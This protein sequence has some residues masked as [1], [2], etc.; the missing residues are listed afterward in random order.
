MNRMLLALAL[1]IVWFQARAE[2]D[3][4]PQ[5]L[6][7]PSTY[8]PGTAFSFQVLVP[9]LPDFT[10]YTI[11]ILFDTEVLDPDLTLSAVP[12]A[13]Q[14]PFPTT[15]GFTSSG[16][17]IAGTASASITFSDSSL[18]GVFTTPGVNDLLAVVTVL[19]GSG[20]TGTITISFGS[21]TELLFNMEGS[22]GFELPDPTTVLQEEVLPPVPVPAPTALLSA[23]IGITLLLGRKRRQR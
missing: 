18:P 22:D 12:V 23:T 19:P 2:A 7:I 3:T 14:Y 10:G 20:M 15:T 4:L 16:G 5:V 17:V 6:D 21:G 13:A 11:E 1:T 8:T 9:G